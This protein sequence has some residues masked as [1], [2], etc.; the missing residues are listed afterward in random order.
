V[1]EADFCVVVAFRSYEDALAVFL[2]P[3][4]AVHVPLGH[5]E[6]LL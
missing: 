6:K 2:P 5:S 3:L 1:G 4:R